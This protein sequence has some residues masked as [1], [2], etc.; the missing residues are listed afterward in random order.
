MAVAANTALLRRRK[1]TDLTVK[2]I[3]WVF[4]GLSLVILAWILITLLMRG[5][6]ALGLYVFTNSMGAPGSGGG[7]L[8]AI[9]GTLIQVAMAL[10]IGAPIGIFAGT[11]LAENGKNTR[12]GSATRFV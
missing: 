10:A 12:I 5:L 11:F 3:S 9:V 6:P 7:L 2:V 1:A 4:A 8:N